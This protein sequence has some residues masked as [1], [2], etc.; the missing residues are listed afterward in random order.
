MSLGRRRNGER[1]HIRRSPPYSPLFCGSYRLAIQPGTSLCFLKSSVR[2]GEVSTPR[3][4]FEKRSASG[5]FLPLTNGCNGSNAA[6]RRWQR[7]L[8]KIGIR[9]RLP[10]RRLV[11]PERKGTETEGY[12]LSY[13]DSTANSLEL[14]F[15]MHRGNWHPK[16]KRPP[17]IEDRG[18][19]GLEVRCVTASYADWCHCRSTRSHS[20][21]FQKPPCA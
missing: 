21:T 18:S 10:I 13:S 3:T 14:T 17:L 1:F 19:H 7:D 8:T 12:D 2:P 4:I 5:R 9:L 16:R 15:G 6:S 11:P 20:G